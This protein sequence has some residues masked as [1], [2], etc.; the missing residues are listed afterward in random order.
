MEPPCEDMADWQYY[1]SG[2][3]DLSETEVEDEDD[4][5]ALWRASSYSPKALT[6]YARGLYTI[7]E[8][9][10]SDT[11]VVGGFKSAAMTLVL[12]YGLFLAV[13]VGFV[14]TVMAQSVAVLVPLSTARSSFAVPFMR[15]KK[16][17]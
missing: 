2:H 4:E 1:E 5:E 6:C 11:M 14:A 15:H 12:A 9:E 3:P 10:T 8:D 13:V 7:P 17:S 16:Y